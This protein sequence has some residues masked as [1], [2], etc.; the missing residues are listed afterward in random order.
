M[1]NESV[2]LGISRRAGEVFHAD[3]QAAP[4]M[5]LRGGYAED[6]YDV[7]PAP[8][9]EL[10]RVTD[11]YLEAYTFWGLGYLDPASWRP[12][13]PRLITRGTGGEVFWRVRG[14]FEIGRKETRAGQDN[15]LGPR[16]AQCG[17]L[18]GLCVNAV[19]DNL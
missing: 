1:Q 19:E 10:D 2:R 15:E 13:L 7:A 8:D 3:A 5:T 4:R 9:A 12:Y 14:V 6:S 18:L 11:G 16:V 17:L